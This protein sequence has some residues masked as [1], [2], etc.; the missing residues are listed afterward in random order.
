[1][2]EMEILTHAK[3]YI[4]K[5]AN[6][7][8]PI[9]DLP[10]GEGDAVN[11][12][13]VSRCLF[14]VSEVLGKVIA[15]GGVPTAPKPK[16]PPFFLTAEQA[17]RFP[18][19]DRAVTVSDIADK[20]NALAEPNTCRK[21]TYAPI[22]HW[23]I[24][25]GALEICTVEGKNLKRPTQRGLEL[26]IK[27]EQRTSQNGEYTAVVYNRAAQQ[28]IVDN[29]EAIAAAEAA[30]KERVKESAGKQGQPWSP[31]Q[32]ARLAELFRAGMSTVNI[33]VEMQRTPGAVS[34]RL[35]HLGI[36]TDESNKYR[37]R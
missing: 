36:D 24:G 9:S 26:G 4:D 28:L 13:R 37:M 14:Y 27:A 15:S 19:T 33:A 8:N 31:E 32:D 3:S 35:K 1:M 21:I 30:K 11:N 18:Y 29:L 17:T 16:L 34:A 5:L 6:G 25:I 23:L 7:I 2:T 22:A 20:L 10:V 12:V